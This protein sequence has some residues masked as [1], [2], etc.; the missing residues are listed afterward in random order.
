MSWCEANNVR[1]VLGLAGNRR[2][3][4]RIAP[5]L[6][7]ARRKA[8]RTGQAGARVRGLSLPHAQELELRAPGDRQGRVDRRRGQSALHRH[9]CA[10]A[11]GGARFLYED[12]YCQR[13][14]MENRL[15]E[16]QG[17][18][19]ADRTPT[20]TMRANQL[21][22]WLSSMAYV[23]M[24]AVRRIGLAGTKLERATCGTIR[25]QL[26]KIGALVTVSVRRVKVAFASAC[27]CATSSA[28]PPKLSEAP[29]CKPAFGHETA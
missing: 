24:C 11:N 19:F 12:V 25:L 8:K 13:G 26:L 23:L 28:S 9:Q 14:E 20:P 21:R 15:K 3:V 10:P 4:A 27:P 1:Y 17:E 6:R 5:E 18:L 16:C 29:R 7:K 2:L 22:L